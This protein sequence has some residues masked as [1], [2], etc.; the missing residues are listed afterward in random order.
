MKEPG[1][2]RVIQGKKL[3]QDAANAVKFVERY[4]GTT[5]PAH[6]AEELFEAAHKLAEGLEQIT[7]AIDEIKEVMQQ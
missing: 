6:K 7:I 3:L 5:T 2:Q 4:W 1:R